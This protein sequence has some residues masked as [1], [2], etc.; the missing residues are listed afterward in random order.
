[1]H[2]WKLGDTNYDGSINI[3]DLI[4]IAAAIDARP[5]DPTWNPRADV[6]QDSRVNLLDLILT[7]KYFDP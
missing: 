6:K 4:F 5:T 7:V 3:L 1:M 2:P